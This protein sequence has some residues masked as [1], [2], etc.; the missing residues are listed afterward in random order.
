M[1]TFRK[2]HEGSSTT[3]VTGKQ[4]WVQSLAY[5]FKISSSGLRFGRFFREWKNFLRLSHLYQLK[6]KSDE[7]DEA[8]DHDKL[9]YSVSKG[10]GT[11]SNYFRSYLIRTIAELLIST[12]LLVW[13]I[14]K[15]YEPFFGENNR[16]QV[17]FVKK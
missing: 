1:E 8:I 2:K 4:V 7:N 3:T 16:S 12:G 17:E 5:T 13:L 14:I 9:A 15:G 10:F 6:N 11:S